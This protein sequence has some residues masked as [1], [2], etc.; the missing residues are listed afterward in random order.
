MTEPGLLSCLLFENK[1]MAE[2]VVRRK[3]HLIRNIFLFLIVVVLLAAAVFFV[4]KLVRSNSEQNPSKATVMQAWSAYDY[5][6]VYD[7]TEIQLQK[8]PLNNSALVYHGYACFF[9]ALS[10]LDTTAAQNYLDEAINCL[11]LALHGAKNHTKGQIEYMLGKS[12][13][14]KNSISSYYYADV[15]VKYLEA[16]KSDG[17][18]ADDISEYL[19][20]SY[21]ALNMTMESISA[22]TEA[23]LVRESFSLLLSIGEQY[24]KAGQGNVAKQYLFRIINGSSNDDLVVKSLNIL[25]NIYIEEENYTDAKESFEQILKKNQNSADAY[26]G[27]GVIYEKQGDLVKARSEWRKALKLHVNHAGALAKIADYK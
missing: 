6:K 9:T 12:Y 24:Y 3:S 26:Y 4:F 13:F 14:Y 8:N 7:L 5:K 20:L 2:T 16:A 1:K 22:F 11:R 18:T 27:L 21:A 15:A 19:G 10:Q 25:G 23:L 17:Y